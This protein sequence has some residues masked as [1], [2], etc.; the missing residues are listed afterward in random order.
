[1][2]SVTACPSWSRRDLPEKP[3]DPSFTIKTLMDQQPMLLKWKSHI[4]GLYGA[5]YDETRTYICMCGNL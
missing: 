1:M 4:Y 2:F 3:D 5:F